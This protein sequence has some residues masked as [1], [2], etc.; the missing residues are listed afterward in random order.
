MAKSKV[1]IVRCESYDEEAIYNAV[2]RGLDLIGG[3]GSIVK[4]DEKI[5]LKVNN[6]AGEKPEEMVTTHP[7]ILNAMIRIM[8]EKN[9]LV[10][11][12]DSPGFGKPKDVLAASGFTEVAER[13]GVRQGDFDDGKTMEFPQ[14]IACKKFEIANA[15]VESDG[16]ISLCKMKTHM[17]TRITGA[18]KNT[19]GCVYGLH[20][21]GFHVRYPN[22]IEFSKM[23]VDLNNLLKPKLYI[24]DGVIAMEGNGPRAGTPVQM[25]CIIISTDPVAVDGTFCRMVDL[26]PEYV[27]T[28]TFG[29]K[30]GLGT[31]KS[32]EI[33]YVGDP[34]DGFVNKKFDVLRKHA[35][36]NPF[37]SAMPSFMRS[38]L[39]KKPF[40]DAEKCI[41]CGV[42][43]KACPVE[44]KALSFKDKKEPPVYDYSKCIRCYCCQELCP[45]KAIGL[46]K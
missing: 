45:S 7:S 34:L 38:M 29:S 20:K 4:D 11:Y 26:D 21:A 24:L 27:P 22:P 39:Y 36:G 46:M 13:Y 5:L 8:Q 35:G 9:I 30:T 6:L 15:C 31:Y 23:L 44:G 2:K 14:G 10:T 32:N 42:C 37:K 40:I 19:F 16:I 17:L 3:I 12:G 43:V 41:R 25:N 33:E 28:N 1:S 18:V